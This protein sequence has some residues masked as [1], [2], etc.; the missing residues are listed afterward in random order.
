MQSAENRLNHCKQHCLHEHVR[1]AKNKRTDTAV[2]A[3]LTYTL[4]QTNRLNR[5]NEQL[6]YT[7]F[8][9]YLTSAAQIHAISK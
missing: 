3:S 9:Y 6:N 2:H 5:L 7:N 8:T 4:R 1:V